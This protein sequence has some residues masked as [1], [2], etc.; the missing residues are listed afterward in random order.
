MVYTEAN[1]L[2]TRRRALAL[3][4]EPH[5]PELKPATNYRSIHKI[6]G[7]ACNMQPLV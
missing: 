2:I 4:R 5:Y 3:S 1:I 6:A 7:N